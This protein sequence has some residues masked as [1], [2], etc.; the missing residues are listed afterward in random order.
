MHEHLRLTTNEVLARLRQDWGADVAAD[1]AIHVQALNM[2]D[3][4]STGIVAQFPR[5]FR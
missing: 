5:R 3:L 1:D 4:L 2:A